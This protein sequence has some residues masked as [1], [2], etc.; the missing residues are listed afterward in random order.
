MFC[1]KIHQHHQHPTSK[2]IVS[3]WEG[4]FSGALFAASFR[5]ASSIPRSQVLS[6]KFTAEKLVGLQDKLSREFNLSHLGKKK[7]IIFKHTLGG[8]RLVPQGQISGVFAFQLIMEELMG[9][10]L[11]GDEND[12]LSAV[13]RIT[14]GRAVEDAANAPH[15]AKRKTSSEVG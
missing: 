13:T 8:D 10:K 6:S 2:T 4:L 9:V 12:C 14:S 11:R 5:E 3:F 15:V 1:L 7:L